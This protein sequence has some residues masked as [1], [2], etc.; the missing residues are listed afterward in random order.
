MKKKKSKVI[1][2]NETKIWK[3]IDI[4]IIGGILL[5]NIIDTL[6]N[7][8][9]WN[10]I[11]INFENITSCILW[12]IYLLSS[13]FIKSIFEITVYIGIRY[14]I[15]KYNKSRTTFD[16]ELDLEYYREKF[17]NINPATMSF[18]MDLNLENT[19]DL[20]SMRLYYELNNIYLYEKDNKLE[21]NNPNNI[22]LTKSDEIL[23]NYLYNN[24]NDSNTLREWKKNIVRDCINNN[25][26]TWNNN[27]R[28]NGCG[29][30]FFINILAFTFMTYIAV[31][32]KYMKFIDLIINNAKSDLE[33]ITM[34]SKNNEYIFM[35]IVL[36]IWVIS[37]IVW[38]YSFIGGIIHF[39]VSNYIT[40]KNKYKRT[41]EGNILTEKLQG[42]KNFIHDFSN[43]DEATKNQLVLWEDF[44]IYAVV[45]EENEVI[46]GEISKL[47][48][49][50]LL[51]YKK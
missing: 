44:L 21:I 30:F 23:L 49:K 45:L 6:T 25:L 29:P 13:L 26:I 24:Q 38:L 2:T 51:I 19:K 46:L 32:D 28:L 48:N 47:Y 41:K 7:K 18:L 43:L 1:I 27:N 34:I 33:A 35:F 9:S 37:S 40:F 11:Y 3:F 4:F 20:G 5:Y 22:N 36:L 17:N 8:T 16:I 42:M 50:N 10:I 12:T 15:K 39:F 31:N 14:S